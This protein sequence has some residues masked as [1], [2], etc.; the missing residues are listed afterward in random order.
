MR[1]DEQKVLSL[2]REL[3]ASVLGLDIDRADNERKTATREKTW[4]SCITVSGPWRGAIVLECP[5]SI[6]R[7]AAAVLA[8]ADGESP[9]NEE[10]QDALGELAGMVGLK[11]RALLPQ[12][13]ELSRPSVAP[14]AEHAAAVSGMHNLGELRLSCEGR[15]VRIAVLEGEPNLAAAQ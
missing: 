14:S 13:V 8:S 15:L 2:S 1:I 3:W 9:S 6:A 11:L 12:R 4:S 10:I 5:E 7:H